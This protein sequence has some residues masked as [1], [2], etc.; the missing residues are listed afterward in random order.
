MNQGAK[1]E[2]VDPYAKFEFAGTILE[3]SVKETTFD[4][5]WNELLIIQG[6]F[7]SMAETII[8]KLYDK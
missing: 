8:L 7:P 2:L 6:N 5:I 3:S 4:P 1:K